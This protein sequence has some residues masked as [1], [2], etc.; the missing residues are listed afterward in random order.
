MAVRSRGWASSSTTRSS[1]KIDDGPGIRKDGGR[2]PVSMTV[3]AMRGDDGR[4]IG[5]VGV[6]HD[7]TKQVAYE[8]R[9]ATR[10]RQV[11]K[12]S[13]GA[14]DTAL[15]NMKQG[16]AMYGADLQRHHLQ[17]QL[18]EAVRAGQG[19]HPA[20]H[21]VRRNRQV[22]DRE[23]LLLKGGPGRLSRRPSEDRRLH[24]GQRRNGEPYRVERRPLHPGDRPRAAVGPVARRPPRTSPN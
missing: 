6:A 13:A 7:I 2:V 15:S 18:H 9:A 1:V 17:R 23:G 16:L 4:I 10:N 19:R 3:S 22:A 5:Y 21:A 20:G 24:G 8:R 14:L 11:G 12:R